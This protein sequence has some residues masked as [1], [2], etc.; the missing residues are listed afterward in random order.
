M[1]PPLDSPPDP[2]S[3]PQLPD[4]RVVAPSSVH[5][6]RGGTIEE[7]RYPATAALVVAGVPGA[8]KSTALHRFF[9]ADA[10]A[11]QPPRG[12]AGSV[13]LDSQHSRNRWRR[14]FGRLPYGLWRPVVH[15]THYAGVRAALRDGAG[16]VVIHDCATFGWARRMIG[17]WAARYGRELHVIL[18]DVPAELARAGQ[19][20]RGRRVSPYF[21]TLHCRRWQRLIHAIAAGQPPRPAAASMV[22]VDRTSIDRLS[23]VSF[24]V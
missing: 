14:R 24:A 12:P 15:I 21:F 23:R 13:V 5:D 1:N 8:G 3:Q 9:G 10:D 17:R 4:M 6:L 20:A 7:L 22:I 19:Y 16:P 2:G 11:E 18:L